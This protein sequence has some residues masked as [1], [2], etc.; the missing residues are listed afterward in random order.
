MVLEV[1][2]KS[3]AKIS[4]DLL[5]LR[6][7]YSSDPVE[8]AADSAFTGQLHVV[9][10]REAGDENGDPYRF[11]I[12]ATDGALGT[13]KLVWG[14]GPDGTI[15][16]GT[17]EYTTAA[18]MDIRNPDDT[19]ASSNPRIPYQL[20]TVA[21]GV[22]TEGD[23]FV[24]PAV[25]GQPVQ[26]FSAR[27]L[28]NGA[29]AEAEFTIAGGSPFTEIIKD[30]TLT[31]YRP[32]EAKE[33]IGSIYDQTI[34]LPGNAEPWWEF[35]FNSTYQSLRFKQALLQGRRFALNTK[36]TGAPIGSTGLYDFAEFTFTN[37]MKLAS[38]GGGQIST[39]GDIPE[40]PVLRSFGANQCVEVWQNTLA[41]ITP[42]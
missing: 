35:G 18:R 2:A 40:N 24:I 3:F 9:G 34:G 1:K 27:P 37:S 14:K 38:V 16:W 11:K 33:G 4:F 26:A 10:H 23:E 42:P 13:A 21:G 8:V 17:T 15:V 29:A 32:R 12:T 39:K 22:F 7:R 28:L 20:L 30:Y 6:D 19:L 41:S 36:L 31:H 5:F 25:S